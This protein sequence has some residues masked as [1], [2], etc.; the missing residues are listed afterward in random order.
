VSAQRPCRTAPVHL[1]AVDGSCRQHTV[2]GYAVCAL[3]CTHVPYIDLSTYACLPVA[4]LGCFLTHIK[5]S[6]LS[7]ASCC[8]QLTLTAMQHALAPSQAWHVRSIAPHRNITPFINR[9]ATHISFVALFPPF[10]YCFFAPAAVQSQ[11]IL[12]KVKDAAKTVGD[13]VNK[14]VEGVK[15]GANT[16]TNGEGAA[17]VTPLS[18]RTA[19][20]LTVQ[21]QRS[22]TQMHSAHVDTACGPA[23]RSCPKMY[24]HTLHS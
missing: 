6:W 10:H 14:G 1:E 21:P 17:P 11:G 9:T 8:M 3:E 12:D 19:V 24:S 20:Y 22:C 15:T 13:G 23:Q 16:V 2:H 5:S 7:L 4:P 18:M